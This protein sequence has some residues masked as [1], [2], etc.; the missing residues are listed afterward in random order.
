MSVRDV[1]VPVPVPEGLHPLCPRCGE[2]CPAFKVALAR[3]AEG[4]AAYRR[5][6]GAWRAEDALLLLRRWRRGGPSVAFTQAPGVVPRA[7]TGS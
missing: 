6:V 2:A 3:G 4:V 1:P 7:S 5:A